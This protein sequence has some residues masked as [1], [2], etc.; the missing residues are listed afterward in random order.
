MT[1]QK[2]SGKLVEIDLL[3][4]EIKK[5]PDNLF[6]STCLSAE[7]IKENYQD[8]VNYYNDELKN[9]ETNLD[10]LLKQ[11]DIFLLETKSDLERLKEGKK[12]LAIGFI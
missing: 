1:Y 12:V 4:D 10:E 6:A 11:V 7:E 5:F 3:A 2:I 8:S 9:N